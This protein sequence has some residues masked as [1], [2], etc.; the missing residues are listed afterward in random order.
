MYLGSIFLCLFEFNRVVLVF[1]KTPKY[2]RNCDPVLNP[3]RS[4]RV[5]E[6]RE[7]LTDCTCRN[8]ISRTIVQQQPSKS[9]PGWWAFEIQKAIKRSSQG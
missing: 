8:R 3:K 4:V 1:V 2:C 7:R 5:W 9:I 6:L